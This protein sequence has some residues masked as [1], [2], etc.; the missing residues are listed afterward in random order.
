MRRT[1]WPPT[2]QEGRSGPLPVPLPF[3]LKFGGE[4]CHDSAVVEAP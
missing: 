4:P 1:R 3:S 2:G